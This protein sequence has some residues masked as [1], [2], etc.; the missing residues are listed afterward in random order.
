[1]HVSDFILLWKRVGASGQ[2][3]IS[4]YLSQYLDITKL[5]FIKNVLRLHFI[6]PNRKLFEKSVLALPQL[7]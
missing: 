7:L 6:G 5:F 1:M 3:Q 4:T 2:L